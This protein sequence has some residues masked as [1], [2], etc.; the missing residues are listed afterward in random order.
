MNTKSWLNLLSE[1]NVESS[2]GGLAATDA[3]AIEKFEHEKGVRLPE[4]YRDYCQVFGPGQL[5]NAFN[6][7]VPG[8][9]GETETY[10]L[11]FLTDSQV[12][13]AEQYGEADADVEQLKRSIFFCIDNS[14]SIHFFDPATGT[15]V[16]PEEYS[17]FTLFRN[18]E[19]EKTASDFN[20]FIFQCCL[21]DKRDYILGVD[22]DD[23]D[24]GNV[25]MIFRPVR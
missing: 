3:A 5:A 7:S 1:L 2:V 13:L 9:E 15:E 14:G 10:S 23:E 20:E 18:Y 17:V 24:A 11:A 16:S 6:I 4:S 8:F 22:E 19:V 21:G 25:P 12:E